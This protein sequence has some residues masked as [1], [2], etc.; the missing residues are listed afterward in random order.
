MNE[1]NNPT[2]AQVTSYLRDRRNWGRW[3]EKG[4]A[5]AILTDLSKAF[6]CLNHDLLIAKLNA[7]GF[8]IDA[9]KF[10]RSYLRGRKQR[11]KVGSEFSRWLDI[12][13]GI[14]QGS[15]LGPLLFNIFLND[16]FYF[17]KDI[18][19]ANYADDN[20]PYAHDTNV[21]SLLE[22]LEKETSTLLELSLIHI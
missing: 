13:F 3:G 4:N 17:I 9:L 8:S 21:I 19:I 12:K 1:R 7:Y 15:I 18:C 6:D 20:T 10:T 22:T 11:T 2:P 5:G 16:I 14:P